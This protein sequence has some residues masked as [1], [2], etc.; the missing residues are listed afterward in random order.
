MLVLRCRTIGGEEILLPQ[1][2]VAKWTCCGCEVA[3]MVQRLSV[4]LSICDSLEDPTRA[5]RRLLACLPR[6]ACRHARRIQSS[7]VDGVCR[8]CLP[9][10][11]S[12]KWFA[13]TSS[14][15]LLVASGSFLGT[16]SSNQK[17]RPEFCEIL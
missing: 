4:C 13:V 6:P 12:K 11:N 17:S 1:I 2:E 15:L 3:A 8:S 5:C 10:H 7:R 9:R 14:R 16:S